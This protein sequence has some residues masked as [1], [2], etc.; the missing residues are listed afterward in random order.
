M[1]SLYGKVKLNLGGRAFETTETTLVG[2]GRNSLFEDMSN[3]NWNLHSGG[4]I[5]QHFIDRNT[6]YFCVLLNLLKKE[7]L[8]SPNYGAFYLSSDEYKSLML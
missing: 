3:E 4:A 2:A 5:T 1:E 7:R 6:N 8:Y